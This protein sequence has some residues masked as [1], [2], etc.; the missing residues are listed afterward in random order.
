M[1]RPLLLLSL[2]ALASAQQSTIPNKEGDF[3]ARDFTFH[4]GEK[5]PELRLHYTTVGEPR[6]DAAGKVRNAVLIVHG[7]GGSGRAFLGAGFGGELFGKDQPLDASKYFVILPDSVGHGRSSKPSDGLHAKFPHYDY[8]DMV[9]AHH[10]LVT[11]GL[12]VD[13]LRLVMGTSMGAMHTWIYGYL[14]P[15]FMDALM[16]LASAPVAIAGRNRMFRAMIMQAIKSDPEYKDGEYTKPPIAGLVAAQYALWMMTS[17]PLQ[18]TNAN[19][20]RERADAA[21]TAL[22]ERA[23]RADANDMLYQYDSSSDYNPSP[24]LGKIRAPLVA[25]NSADDEVNP[26]ELGFL[27]REIQKVARGKYILIP[28]TDQ[29][30][31]HGTHSRA[32]LWK[33]YFQELMETS[34]P[35]ESLFS[36]RDLDL[37][38]DPKS[39]AW[40]DAPRV[41]ASRDF[42]GQPISGPPTEIRSRWTKDHLYLH[43]TCPFDELNLKPDPN[44]KAKTAQLWNWDVAEAFIG[45]DYARIGAYK[46]FQVS[47]QGEWIDLDINR[48]DPKAQ[49]FM[50]WNSGFTVAA[51]IDRDAKVW[52]GVMRIPWKSI[53]TRAPEPG[54]ELRIGLY[55]IAGRDPN[56]KYYAWRPTG[57]KSFH[58]PKAFGTLRLK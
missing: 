9:R 31:G 35:L 56:K 19:P 8:E 5:L 24:H 41:T 10:R 6:R 7:T 29:T 25:I 52:Y 16:P 34:E 15:E 32:A 14:Y 40:A 49:Q 17:S 2:A 57:S 58:V 50:A 22:R 46:E 13:R 42:L 18:L 47:P 11:E 54:R 39:P 21:I 27:E 53:D 55:R 20:T 28:T 36:D 48:D 3:V 12:G 37:T 43:Y 23:A 30:R 51:R 33:P 45:S 1:L 44:P 26:P 4:T 38:L